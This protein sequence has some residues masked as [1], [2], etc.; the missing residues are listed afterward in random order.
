MLAE[1]DLPAAFAPRAHLGE[2]R[3][4]ALGCHHDGLGPFAGEVHG[5]REEQRVLSPGVPEEDEGR[6]LLGVRLRPDHHLVA[7][8][9]AQHDLHAVTIPAGL[10][11]AHRGLVH[12]GGRRSEA[13]P[14]QTRGDD[15]HRGRDSRTCPA[16]SPP[17]APTPTPHGRER[18][19]MGRRRANRRSEGEGRVHRAPRRRY[20][21]RIVEDRHARFPPGARPRPAQSL[22]EGSVRV[23]PGRHDGRD[24]LPGRP[25]RPVPRA[26]LRRRRH[27]RRAGP[28]DRTPRALAP[29]VAPPAGSGR[30]VGTRR[31]RALLALRRGRGGTGRRELA[32]F[33]LRNV[34]VPSRDDRR[35]RQA[36]RRLPQRRRTRLRRARAR[37][38]GGDRAGLRPVVPLAAGADGPAPRRGPRPRARDGHRRGRRG[39]WRG[40]RIDRDGEGVPHLRFPRLRDL[41]VRVGAGRGEPAGRGRRERDLPRRREGSASRGTAASASSPPSTAC[42]T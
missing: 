15:P 30:R 26:R 36:S 17:S 32:G 22:L 8:L 29:G 28:A 11:G 16:A 20:H 12:G 39:L 1:G 34:L 14:A 31:R 3:L 6:L 42:T 19:D 10:E 18:W 27:L 21:R 2:R 13:R 37:R 9:V 33:R 25:P 38:G 4:Q 40:R 23:A 35:P 7:A 41:P 5:P 24:D